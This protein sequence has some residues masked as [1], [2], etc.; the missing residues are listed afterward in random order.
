MFI[1]KQH[2]GTRSMATKF[3]KTPRLRLSLKDQVGRMEACHPQFSV[4]HWRGKDVE[5]EGSLTPSTSSETYRVRITYQL[6]T[7]PQVFVLSPPLCNGTDKAS[8]PHMYGDKSLCLFFP[9]AGEWDSSMP[10][11][12]TIIPWASSWLYFYEVWLSTG[13]WS[14]G[15]RHPEAS[16]RQEDT[17]K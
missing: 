13:V 17:V 16:P 10:I 2:R 8:P 7:Y 9:K 1:H 4:K 12:E 5:W 11:A 3:Y 14:G 15:G 6:G